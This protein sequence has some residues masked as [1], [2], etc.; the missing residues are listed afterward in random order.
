MHRPQR[1]AAPKYFPRD[2]DTSSRSSS[3]ELSEDG[4]DWGAAETTPAPSPSHQHTE[5]TEAEIQLMVQRA[6][7]PGCAHHRCACACC[8]AGIDPRVAVR[9]RRASAALAGVLIARSTHRHD[10]SAS[11]LAPLAEVS[12]APAVAGDGTISLGAAPTAALP[13][14]LLPRA[15]SPAAAGGGSAAGASGAHPQGAAAPAEAAP[16]NLCEGPTGGAGKQGTARDLR[17]LTLPEL[18]TELCALGCDSVA[19]AAM[20]RWTLVRE[21]QAACHLQ[22]ERLGSSA[23]QKLR[24]WARPPRKP[25]A[26]SS[27]A[28]RRWT[29]EEDAVLLR[30]V[31]AARQ[32]TAHDKPLMRDAY[33]ATIEELGAAAGRTRWACRT[34]WQKELKK[35]PEHA[36]L[37][38][39][40]ARRP[41]ASSGD[42]DDDDDDYEDEDDE[43][44]DDEEDSQMS[45]GVAASPAPSFKA[46]GEG[47]QNGGSDAVSPTAALRPAASAKTVGAA[48]PGGLPAA[49]DVDRDVAAP[50]VGTFL[51]QPQPAALRCVDTPTAPLPRQSPEKAA[52]PLCDRLRA[53]ERHI[54]ESHARTVAIEGEYRR[55]KAAE[56]VVERRLV[57]QLH[58]LRAELQEEQAREDAQLA[59]LRAEKEAEERAAEE[60]EEQAAQLVA[61]AVARR[62][63]AA[64]KAAAAQEFAAQVEKKRKREE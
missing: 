31:A 38:S 2:S 35:K 48:M 52:L 19:V 6:A 3:E 11:V 5:G 36:A 44:D 49:G 28:G 9:S 29:A 37:A 7:A 25:R 22:V 53:V 57:H 39:M 50:A 42:D 23:P 34:R 24:D 59:R 15:A 61:A 45:D 51:A 4:E 40:G 56:E 46:E 63:S 8:S 14:P 54:Q 20:P 12:P 43:L 17:K 62:A 60:A 47:Q 1:A 13:S 32:S 27:A 33:D 18:K 21:L 41:G 26:S 30:H 58:A 10:A 16:A 55:K 64:A